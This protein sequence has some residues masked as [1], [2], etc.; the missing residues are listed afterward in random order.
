MKKFKN[1][2]LILIAFL[3]FNRCEETQVDDSTPLKNEQL[4]VNQAKAYVESQKHNEFVLKSGDLQKQ[5]ISIR[6]NWEKSQTSS[7]NN[8]SIVETEIEAKGGFGFATSESIDAWEK[9]KNNSY[10]SS[11]SRLVVIKQKKT[12]EM[13]T[14]IMSVVADKCYLESKKYNLTDNTYLKREK[15]LSGYILFHNLN[16]QFVNGWVYVNGEVVQGITQIKDGDL[17]ISLKSAQYI[18]P[19]YGWIEHEVDWYS[20]SSVGGSV[21]SVTYMY[22]TTYWQYEIVGYYDTNGNTSGSTTGGYIP[23][24]SSVP[25]NCVETC[26]ICGKCLQVLKLAPIP[27]TGNETNPTT[28]TTT[29]DCGMCS[30]HPAPVVD[31]S[32]L[33]NNSKAYCIYQKLLDGGTLSNF[34]GRYFGI[35]QSNEAFLGE[36]NLT[37]ALDA[38]SA[39]GITLP[40]GYTGNNSYY[41]VKIVINSTTLN[42]RSSTEVAMTMLH[43]ALHAKLIGEFYDSIGSTDFKKLFA[44]YKG[45]GTGEINTNQQMEMLNVY[46]DDMASALQSFDQSQGINQSLSIYKEALKYQLSR[47]I[48]GNSLYPSGSSSYDLLKNSSKNCN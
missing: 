36:L 47:D 26:P 22:T 43:E 18:A 15:D 13:F 8:F 9:T 39:N 17:S 46:A 27:P 31:A 4:T 40:I 1:L 16:G 10:L 21:V 28:T 42:T 37:W 20:V 5:S 3:C 33:Q 38:I 2:V 25:C 35:S 14:F 24:T 23:P 7:D 44:Y 12:G 11:M 34:I 30:G 32:S 48:W 29:S 45:W 19:F 6:A 41:S